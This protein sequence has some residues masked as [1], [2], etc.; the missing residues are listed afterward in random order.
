MKKTI[1][2]SAMAVCLSIVNVNANSSSES[3]NDN[4]TVATFKVSAFCLSVVKGDYDTVKKLIDLGTDVNS[5]SNGMTPAM[6]AAKFNRTEIL[7]LLIANGANLKVK[8]DQGWTAKKYAELS[9]AN[10][11]VSVI[12][13]ALTKR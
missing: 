8:S 13:N 11:A 2:I 7:E 1:I 4:T 5:R 6:Y 3:F 9:N 12:E 10:E